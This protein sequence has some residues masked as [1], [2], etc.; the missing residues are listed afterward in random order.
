VLFG[1]VLLTEAQ[2][3]WR[4]AVLFTAI[5]QVLIKTADWHRRR[6]ARA[7][8]AGLSNT[9]PPSHRPSNNGDTNGHTANGV[10]WGT[11][12]SGECPDWLLWA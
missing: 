2:H 9:P 7:V 6:M 11:P 3:S 1:S 12:E 8:R 5:S 10:P 4:P